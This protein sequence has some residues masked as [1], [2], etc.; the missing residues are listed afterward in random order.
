MINAVEDINTERKNL[1]LSIKSQC[2]IRIIKSLSPLFVVHPK[3][4]DHYTTSILYCTIFGSRMMQSK[5]LGP[6]S[7]Q[8]K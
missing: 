8:S 1:V 2:F 4:K 6:E 5:R 3:I 7:V